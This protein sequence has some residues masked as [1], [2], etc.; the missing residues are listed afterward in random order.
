MFPYLPGKSTWNQRRRK[1]ENEE[2][3][4]EPGEKF[5]SPFPQDKKKCLTSS[6]LGI[7]I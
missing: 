2:K 5:P 6:L 3:K 4:E 1:G 7:Y